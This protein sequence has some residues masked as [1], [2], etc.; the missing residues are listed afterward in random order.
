MSQRRR[1]ETLEQVVEVDQ[2]G[3]VVCLFW[4]EETAEERARVN[5]IARARVAS[6]EYRPGL[7]WRDG[8][9][10]VLP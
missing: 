5:A 3:D 2:G 7:Y 10:A 9:E 6:G 4:S 8:R 1:V